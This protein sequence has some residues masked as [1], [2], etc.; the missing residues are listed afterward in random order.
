M[1]DGPAGKS[2]AQESLSM[3]QLTIFRLAFA[4]TPARQPNAL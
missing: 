4:P 2:V 1:N 3:Q